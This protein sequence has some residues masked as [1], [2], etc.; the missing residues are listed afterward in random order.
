MPQLAA[1]RKHRRRIESAHGR[2][3]RVPPPIPAAAILPSPSLTCH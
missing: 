2:R 3:T 1:W